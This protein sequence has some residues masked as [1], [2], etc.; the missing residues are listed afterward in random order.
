MSFPWKWSSWSPSFLI[1]GMHR[2]PLGH[3]EAVDFFIVIQKGGTFNIHKLA[4]ND[5]LV[6]IHGGILGINVAADNR[7][8]VIEFQHFQCAA[9]AV[10]PS[11][12]RWTGCN[13]FHKAETSFLQGFR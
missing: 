5:F 1:I 2:A 11:E 3:L 9:H 4:H 6:N 8:S 12:G 13:D 10:S 7:T